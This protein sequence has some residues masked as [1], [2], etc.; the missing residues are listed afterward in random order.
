MPEP[1]TEHE[2]RGRGR[3][4]PT[5][6]PVCACGSS[7]DKSAV[8]RRGVGGETGAVR[9]RAL[10]G[11]SKRR[12][13]A[14][15][16]GCRPHPARGSHRWRCL[17]TTIRRTVKR[18]TVTE[19]KLGA[20]TR[21]SAAGEAVGRK[22]RKSRTAPEVIKYA[23]TNRPSAARCAWRARTA[24]PRKVSRRLASVLRTVT[25]RREAKLARMGDDQWR[26]TQYSEVWA[27]VEATP[28]T[29]N[30]NTSLVSA[31][32]PGRVEAL[33][34]AVRRRTPPS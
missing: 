27:P 13:G 32:R 12:N 11:G 24:D 5:G 19:A 25:T 16:Q 15:G 4:A 22:W 14:C 33:C 9:G 8:R 31:G 34:C 21:V 28:I 18:T 3:R 26:R 2:H 6:G 20:S 1:L 7:G 10:S 17:K 29:T 30:Q 23:R